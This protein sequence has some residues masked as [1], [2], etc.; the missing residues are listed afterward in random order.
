MSKHYI[1]TM[2]C[3]HSFWVSELQPSLICHLS[4][5]RVAHCSFYNRLNF[6]VSRNINGY[7]Y[8]VLT[9]LYNIWINRSNTF[10]AYTK[11]RFQV[12]Y[13]HQSR[14]YEVPFVTAMQ[15]AVVYKGSPALWGNLPGSP[16]KVFDNSE[17]TWG[18]QTHPSFGPG[19]VGCFQSKMAWGSL[20]TANS[21][22]WM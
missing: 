17:N 20:Q 8:R 12:R 9:W 6:D 11:M 21:I 15:V 13:R 18:K 10:V 2:R 16:Q 4:H 19:R 3:R 22:V 1:W 5:P 14:I 7:G